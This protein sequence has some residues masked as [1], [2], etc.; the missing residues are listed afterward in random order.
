MSTPAIVTQNTY[1]GWSVYTGPAN[2]IPL[3][4]NSRWIT[5]TWVGYNVNSS[6][7]LQQDID[8]RVAALVDAFTTARNSL[9][10]S[11]KVYATRYFCVPE[12]YFHS[13]YGPYPSVEIQGQGVFEYIVT[14]LKAALGAIQLLPN[15][16]WLVCIGSTLTVNI[17]DIPTFLQ[18]DAVTERLNTLNKYVSQ[19][20]TTVALGA[21]NAHI[22][23]HSYD[24]PAPLEGSAEEAID[25][26]MVNYRGDPLC[27]V[28]NRCATI[29]M[30]TSGTEA[31]TFEKQN[32]STVDLT[33]GKL[34]VSGGKKQLE[35]GYMI[36]EWLGNYPS[37][38]IVNGDMNMPTQPYAARFTIDDPL[39][40]SWSPP[41]TL[42]I[43]FEICLDHRL[44]RLRRTV[45]M[46]V[47]NG[48]S[49]DNPPL[50]IQMIPS[51]GMQILSQ[52]VV[53]DVA[54]AIFN[55]DGCDPI[56][57]VYTSSGVPVI[58][59]SGTYKGIACGVYVSCAQNMVTVNA[60]NYYSHTQLCFR[61]GSDPTTSY[62]NALGNNN[63]PA[64]T[65]D[66][67]TQKNPTLDAYQ[68]PKIIAVSY[69]NSGAIFAAG[70]GEVHL[71]IVQGNT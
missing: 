69:A 16:V 46:T 20:S 29:K 31:Y 61:Y 35:T 9:S 18:S 7:D 41:Q 40:S 8:Y 4:T 33:M 1:I 2:A 70:S 34:V 47:A 25:M 30:N 22:R 57:N 51:G 55:G 14:S 50:A 63:V 66:Q 26:L 23:A 13:Q 62:N 53:S 32:E 11:Q 38:S 17:E 28:R 21:F 49:A 39:W 54:G 64:A 58:N 48:A 6:A 65:Y 43:G 60:Q 68:A 27:T 42:Q 37:I 67:G 10:D 56:L 24:A 45:D 52:S 44:Q 71:Y 59:G 3:W 19:L 12:F 36:T 5:G 15:E